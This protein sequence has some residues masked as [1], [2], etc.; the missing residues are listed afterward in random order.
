MAGPQA[1]N[2]K[3]LKQER[4]TSAVAFHCIEENNILFFFFWG[5]PVKGLCAGEAALVLVP[6]E[7]GEGHSIV[8]V[9]E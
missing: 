5:P 9:G 4:E 1:Q 3:A 8:V 6:V 7:G 2:Q